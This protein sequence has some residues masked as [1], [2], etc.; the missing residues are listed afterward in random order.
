MKTLLLT[1]ALALSYA[2]SAQTIGFWTLIPNDKIKFDSTQ[3]EY[4]IAKDYKQIYVDEFTNTPGKELNLYVKHHTKGVILTM[5]GGLIMGG[6]A[7][8]LSQ[9]NSVLPKI[10]MLMGGLLSLTGFIYILE[11]PVHIKRAAIILNA[12]GVGIKYKL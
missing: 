7:G 5:A 8:L 12:T 9:S 3:N 6:G 4:Y 10:G 2:V 1:I 11:A